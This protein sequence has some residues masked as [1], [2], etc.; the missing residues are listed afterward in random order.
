MF[1]IDFRWPPSILHICVMTSDIDTYP[2]LCLGGCVIR[3][4][5]FSRTHTARAIRRHD[6][7]NTKTAAYS[8][9][10]F[11]VLSRSTIRPASNTIVASPSALIVAPNTFQSVE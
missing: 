6:S 5:M 3:P 10:C 2:P 1:A 11:G 9:Q 8:T 7:K 4:M